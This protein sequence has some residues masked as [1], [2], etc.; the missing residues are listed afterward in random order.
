M[1]LGVYFHHSSRQAVN[2]ARGTVATS[3]AISKEPI[4]VHFI[5]WWNFV[6]QWKYDI[7]ESKKIFTNDIVAPGNR[8]GNFCQQGRTYWVSQDGLKWFV[9]YLWVY[10]RSRVLIIFDVFVQKYY[11]LGFA[12]FS[13]S[14]CF[15][16]RLCDT[17]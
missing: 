10:S 16:L 14:L 3:K 15:F 2:L 9:W 8:W 5:I 7:S 13:V 1:V 12:F 4:K 6:S 17:K 11:Q